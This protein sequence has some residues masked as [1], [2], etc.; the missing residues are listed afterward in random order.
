MQHMIQYNLFIY[1]II[2]AARKQY[3][4]YMFYL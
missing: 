1:K 4:I 3:I 2:N